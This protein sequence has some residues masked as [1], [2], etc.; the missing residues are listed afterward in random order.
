MPETPPL[1]ERDTTG[2]LEDARHKLYDAGETPTVERQ[3]LS[4]SGDPKL[5]HAWEDTPAL[6]QTLG[7]APSIR[8]AGTFFS[9]A[10]VFFLVSLGVAGYFFYF[11]SNSVSSDKIDLTIQGPTTIAGGD[12]VPLKLTIVNKNPVAIDNA[13][14]QIDFPESTRNASNTLE[15]YPRYTENLGRIESGET[16]TRSLRAVLFGGAGQT[17]TLPAAFSYTTTGTN[18]NFKK[19][20]SYTLGISTTPLEL[21]LNT[22]SETVSGKPITFSLTVRSNATLPLENVVLA[23]TFP[24]GFSVTSSSVPLTGSSF[25]LGTMAPGSSKTVTLTGVLSGQEQEERVFH[26]DVGTAKSRTDT[27][28]AVTYMKQEAAITLTAPFINT[29]LVINGDSSPTPILKAGVSQNVTL[30]YA[31]TLSTAVNNLTVA[32]TIAGSAVDYESIRSTQGFYRSGDRTIVFSQDR[33][34]SLAN[35]A[36]GASGVGSFSFK[37]L[38]STGSSPTVTFTVSVAGTRVGQSNVPEQV[39][40]S[41]SRIAKVITGVV[42]SADA[43]YSTGSIPNTGPIPPQPDQQTSYTIRW[44]VRNPGSAVADGSVTATL[45]SYVTYT[46]KT[47]GSGSLVY[48]P[49]ARKLTWKMGELPQGGTAQ[50]DFQIVLTPSTSQIGNSPML[51]STSNFSGHDRFAGIPVQATAN[52]V[53]TETTSEAGYVRGSGTVQ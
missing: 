24:F 36:P 9:F 11:G 27:A 37:T 40:A 30:S 19:K 25:L 22:L 52:P 5:P 50:T 12:T 45:P 13:V 1:P 8:W 38:S 21:S 7:A 26:F 29:T 16:V 32:V 33:D 14:I 18:A 42:L 31:N 23:G 34:P 28:L 3:P 46:N 53:D 20:A 44:T 47:S 2:A 41:L 15:A 48:D 6:A 35:F 39:Q 49:S 43:L 10:L 17:V 4:V 51:I